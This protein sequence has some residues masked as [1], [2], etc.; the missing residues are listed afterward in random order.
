VADEYRVIGRRLR[1]QDAGPRLTGR[2]RYTADLSLPGMLHARFVLSSEPHARIKSIHTADALAVPGVSALVTADDLP[3]F[4]RDDDQAVRESFF[5]PHRRVSYVG[6]PLAVVL[7]ES[8]EA[9][10]EA[11]DLVRVEF[12]R[13]PPVV[14]LEAALAEDAPRLREDGTSNAAGQ[15]RYE[16]GDVEAAFATA[17]ATAAG[18]FISDGVYQSYMEPRAVLAEAD[19]FGALTIYTPT[20][21]QFAMRQFVA[22]ALRMSEADVIVR[23]MTVG[24]GFG[25]KFVLFEALIGLLAIQSGRPVKLVLDRGDDFLSTINAPRAAYDLALAADAGG[26]V[27]AIRADVKHDTG[28]FSH[29]PYQLTGLLIGSWYPAPNLDITSTEV[30]TNRPGAAAYRAPGLTAMAFALEQLVDDLAGQLGISPLEIRRRNVARTG[31]P[32]A[33]GAPWPAQELAK[34]LDAARDHPLLSTPKGKKEGVGISIGMMRGATEPASATARLAGDGSLQVSVGSI[35]ITGTNNGIAQIVAETFGLPAEKVRVTTAPS[36]IAPHS[37]GSGGSKILYTVGNAAIL[38]ARDA[39]NQTLAVAAG[40]LEVAPDDLEIVDGVV[41]VVGSPDRRLTLERVFRLTTGLN[42]RHAPIHGQGNTA[43]VERAPGVTV[44]IVRVRVEQETGRIEILD[45]AALHDAG[46]AINPSEVE[47]QIYGGVAQGIGWALYEALLYDDAGQPM[48][49]SYMDYALPKAE[50]IP[51][52]EALIHE[53]P[54]AHGPFGA[55]GIGEPPVIPSAA[56]IANA[57]HDAAGVRLRHLPMTAERVWRAL[58]N[59]A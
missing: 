20:Q 39:R 21:G 10:R 56:A 38:A 44:H 46:K 42:A 5:L 26:K 45:Y 4:A 23:P 50:Q 31:Q 54:A 29:S 9:A 7:A 1:R 17:A 41:R 55:K 27:T 34:L 49:A 33:D 16:R 30:Y 19:P 51:Q 32:M 14:D 48:T 43:N 12:E 58:Q 28:Y 25:A 37:G 40:E 15:V 35:D 24:G 47:N 3:E 11:V 22:A 2:E 52:V 8:P 53:F 59:G 18:R 36:H 57:I 13:L 6:Q